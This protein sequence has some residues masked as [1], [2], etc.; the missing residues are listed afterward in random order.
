MQSSECKV[1]NAK[2][3]AGFCV[4]FFILTCA[5]LAAQEG[6]AVSTAA[7]ASPP[8]NES[9][10]ML[11]LAKDSRES[12]A[13]L[14]YSIRWDFS[15]LAHI[16]PNFKTLAEGISSIARWDI[17]E[18]TRV[19]YYGLR[20]NPWRLFIARERVETVPA[21]GGAGSQITS[22]GPGSPVYKKRVRLSLSPLVDD[23]K[24]DLDENLRNALLR[25][26]LKATGPQWEK[27]SRQGQK[28]FFSDLLSL[29]IWD[30][31]VLDTTKE[32]L[33]YISK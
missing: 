25:N 10:L 9:Q 28:S 15:D 27:V 23:F 19:K 22:A 3:G 32:G 18:N 1:R 2:R 12:R 20:T 11:N 5:P 7:P 16:R 6:A 21:A 24:R 29:E 33:E 26:S 30:L 8:Q 31:P 4:V 13:S 17:T 14:D